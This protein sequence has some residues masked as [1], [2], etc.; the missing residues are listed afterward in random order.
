MHTLK[1]TL[2]A[3]TAAVLA[4]TLPAMTGPALAYAGVSTRPDIA[5]S[6]PQV[7]LQPA[8]PMLSADAFLSATNTA[9]AAQG[10]PALVL[11]QALVTAAQM[12]VRDMQVNLYWSHFRPSDNKAPWDFMKE[13]GYAYDVAGENLA[14]GFRTAEGI[15]EGWLESPT[16]R[17]NLLS[18]LYS[19]VGYATGTTVNAQ[20]EPVLVTVQF[21]ASPAR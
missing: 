9:R 8:S 19:E 2:H 13:A 18:P 7:P 6:T 5:I 15:T 14:R 1:N 21:L 12:K 3:F 4:V 16:H 17:A 11:N 10:M 20:G